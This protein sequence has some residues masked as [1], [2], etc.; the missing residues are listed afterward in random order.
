MGKK[1]AFIE[2]ANLHVTPYYSLFAIGNN[3]TD[4]ET[5]KKIPVRGIL[6]G[7]YESINS[8]AFVIIMSE[9]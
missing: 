2:H 3:V 9:K 5:N 4:N 8:K 6:A 1:I 7:I